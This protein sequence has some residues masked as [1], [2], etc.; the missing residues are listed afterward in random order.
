MTKKM[1]LFLQNKYSKCYFRI[2]EKSKSRKLDDIYVEKHHIFPKSLDGDNSKENVI[3]L[4]AKEHFICHLLLTKMT[5]N[6]FQKLSKKCIFTSPT[7]EQFLYDRLNIG[8][9]IHNFNYGSVKN[10]IMSNKPYKGWKILY[11]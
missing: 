6:N 2:I 8:C 7:G 5:E 3:E 10:N 11:G 4:T 1:D 9:K